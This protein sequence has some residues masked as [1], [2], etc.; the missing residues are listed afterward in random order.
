MKAQIA[1]PASALLL[2]LSVVTLVYTPPAPSHSHRGLV[3]RAG[4]GAIRAIASA[5]KGTIAPEATRSAAPL[6]LS[7]SRPDSVAPVAGPADIATIEGYCERTL[8]TARRRTATVIVDP[9]SGTAPRTAVIVE[10]GKKLERRADGAK[11]PKCTTSELDV[12]RLG[13]YLQQAASAILS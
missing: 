11:K 5:D 1:L 13:S 6:T 8:E 2:A 4:I 7:S 10:F 12:P 9:A 3:A